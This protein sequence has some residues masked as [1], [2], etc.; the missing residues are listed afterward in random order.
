[1]SKEKTTTSKKE[2]A[3]ASKKEKT[4]TPPLRLDVSVRLVEPKDNLLG[5]ASVMV[6]NAIVIDDFSIVQ[7]DNGIFAGMPSKPDPTRDSGYKQIVRPMGGFYNQLSKQIEQAYHAQVEKIQAHAK[8]HVK[9]AKSREG[10]KSIKKDIAEGKKQ[11]EK[12]NA[13]RAGQGSPQTKGREEK[14]EPPAPDGR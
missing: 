3:T 13:A 11:A 10:D 1:M 12:E 9:Y 7:G 6:N 2:K 4:T 5:F 14:Q 8:A